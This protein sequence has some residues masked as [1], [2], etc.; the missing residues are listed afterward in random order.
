MDMTLEINR[1]LFLESAMAGY[2]ASAYLP[3]SGGT[4]PGIRVVSPGAVKS[5]VRVGLLYLGKSKAHW[6][7]P[8]LNL[9]S[10][11]QSYRQLLASDRAFR[12]VKFV[13][14]RMVTSPQEVQALVQTLTDVDGLLLIHVSMGIRD[15][16][17]EALKL[18]K[19]TVLFAQ[20]YSGHEWSGFGRLMEQP[21]GAL[22]DCVL[23]SDRSQIAEII[24]SFRAIHHL[25]EARILDV[26]A[27]DLPADYCASVK[28]EF[29]T[30]II[31]VGR[32]EV[33]AAYE[34]IDDSRAGRDARRLI[35]HATQVLEPTRDEIVRSCKLALAFEKLLAD[36]EATAITV[37]CYGTMYRQ[38]PAFP[39]VGFTRIND[40]GLAGV[41]EADLASAMTFI[42]LQSLSGRP[43][44]ISDPTV[45]ESSNSIVLAHCLGSTRM[46][47][48]DGPACP[49]KMRSI[50]ERQEGA[51]MQVRMRRGQKA[52]QAEL[53]GTDRIVY[54]TGTIS[55]TPESDRGCRTKIAVQ[56]DGDVRT[57][58]RNWSAG[59]HRV[60]CYGDLTVDLRRFCRFKSIQLDNEAMPTV[61]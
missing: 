3:M 42:L 59:L 17:L 23:S 52:T 47:G 34:A 12:D 6:P 49:Y 25:R 29:G 30:E 39:C 14:D 51:V 61:A 7:T 2:L 58:W 5:K 28:K 15:T 16:L 46:D 37:D 48:P 57:L 8:D 32:D 21:E 50:M 22:L 10:E 33:M 36:M 4:T 54:F 45:D 56:V 24:R 27:R 9:E 44:F 43:G 20:P 18:N 13:G 26:T 41:C 55:D 60:T 1:R 19:P 53:V 35:A 31:R 38:L 11:V 40:Q